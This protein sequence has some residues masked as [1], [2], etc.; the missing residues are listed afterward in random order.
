[1]SFKFHFSSDIFHARTDNRK[2]TQ[3]QVADA[4][5]ISLRA[6][7]KIEKGEHIPCTE[8][9]LRLVFFFGLNIENYREEVLNR[10]PVYS[11]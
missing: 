4:V 8:I 9:F 2:L 5:Y 11:F 10:V 1:M 3:Q 7:Q 6:Y